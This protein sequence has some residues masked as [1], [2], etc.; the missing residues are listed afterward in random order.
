MAVYTSYLY[1]YTIL[2]YFIFY[3][4]LG[5]ITEKTQ[6]GVIK[7]SYRIIHDLMEGSSKLS[8]LSYLGEGE[9]CTLLKES[10]ICHTDKNTAI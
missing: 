4:Y 5:L 10:C 9:G 8:T 2:I 3:V 1:C 6:K 7:V